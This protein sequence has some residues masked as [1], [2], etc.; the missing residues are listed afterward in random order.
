M[1]GANDRMILVTIRKFR[2][3]FCCCQVYGQ[4]KFKWLPIAVGELSKGTRGAF[5]SETYR[6]VYPD[7][8][9][10]LSKWCF[11]SIS[12]RTDLTT[13]ILTKLPNRIMWSK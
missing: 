11:D 13:L 9:N 8:D 6:Y 3:Y 7:A 4:Q 12:S 1:D 2:K 10:T 5:Q